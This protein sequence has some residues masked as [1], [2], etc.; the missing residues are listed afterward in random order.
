VGWLPTE[1]LTD[2]GEDIPGTGRALKQHQRVGAD[3][4]AILGY[5]ATPF[6]ITASYI[7][8]S[9]DE[10]LGDGVEANGFQGGFLEVNWVPVSGLDYVATPWLIFARYDMVRYKSGPGDLDGVTAGV[11]RYLALGPR[12]SLA[13]HAEVHADWTKEVG[14]PGDGGAPLD[15]ESQAV[16]LGLDYDF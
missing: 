10:A 16:V 6:M 3:V 12:S 13:V 9:E 14:P 8:G 4:T 11:R 15:V 7:V 2:G 1:F 5:P